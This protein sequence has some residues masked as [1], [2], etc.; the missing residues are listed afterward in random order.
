MSAF[1][2]DEAA[3]EFTVTWAMEIPVARDVEDAARRALAHLTRPGSLATSFL[4]TGRDGQTWRVDLA[5]EIETHEADR[6]VDVPG[7]HIIGSPWVQVVPSDERPAA[8]FVDDEQADRYAAA[9]DD[10]SQAEP[11][12][13]WGT[14]LG[15]QMIAEALDD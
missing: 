8:V 3:A 11:A 7:D 1:V 6:I 12:Q 13:I 14:Q 5:G 15:E 4:V 10:G 9:Y 2:V